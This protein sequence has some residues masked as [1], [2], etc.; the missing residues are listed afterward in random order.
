MPAVKTVPSPWYSYD[1]GPAGGQLRGDAFFENDTFTVRGSGADIWGTSDAFHFVARC[2]LDDGEL[3][4]RVTTEQNA[5][6]FG[7]AGVLIRDN[8]AT[9]ILDIRPNGLIEFMSRQPAA[10]SQMA[11]VA[12]A[13]S[14]FPAW[15]KLVRTGDQ[16]SGSI[17]DDGR[18]WRLVG[19]TMVPMHRGTCIEGGLAVTSHDPAAL[20]TSTFDHVSAISQAFADSDVGDVGIAGSASASAVGFTVNGAGADIWGTSDAFN[21]LS[22]GIFGDGQ[23]VAR[24]VALQNTDTFAK[25]GVMIRESTDPSAAHVILDVR[26]DGQIEFMT[27]AASGGT[28]AFIAGSSMSFPGWLKLTRTGSLVSGFASADG[29]N[30]RLVGSTT[31]SIPSDALTGLAVTS[32]RRGVINTATFDSVGR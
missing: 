13:A 10:G 26:P 11:F 6:T 30:W 2:M 21:F 3:I 25:A 16:F 23:M 15:L 22:R 5:D 28:T 8:S 27:R 20:N 18:N 7:K 14:S 17:S 29:Q 31:L 4:A 9:V 32:H 24:V 19:T 12:G 1:S